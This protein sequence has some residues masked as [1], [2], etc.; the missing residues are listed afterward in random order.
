MT[1]KKLILKP[2][3]DREN[4]RYVNEGK[5]YSCDK[6]RF[7]QGTPEKI[8]GWEQ[9]SA[10]TYLGVARSLVQWASLSGEP[11]IGVGTN[12]KY[13][14]ASGGDYYDITPIRSSVVLNNPFDTTINDATVTVHDTAHGAITGDFVTFSG[15]TAVGGLDLNSEYQVTVVDVDT[16]T[17]EAASQASATVTGGGGATVTA[18][19]QLNVGL[20]VQGA[21]TGW[22]AGGWGLGPWGT[23][24]TSTVEI[25]IWNAANFG[26]NLVYGPRGGGIYYWDNSGGL[27]TRGVE[28]GA[29]VGASDTPDFQNVL[30]VSD[31]SRFVIAFGTNTIGSSTQDPMLI[32]WSDQED[33]ANWSPGATS[34]AGELRLS[35]GSAIISAIQTRQEIVVLTDSAVYSMQYAGAP[36]FWTV[37]LLGDNVSIASDRAVATASN[38]VYWMGIDKF[39]MYDG[40]VQTL[41]CDLRQY[42]FGDINASQ[43]D[44]IFS[45]TVEAFN[46]V[47]WF[48]CSADSSTV[49]RYVVYNYVEN[50]WYYGTLTRTAWVDS[51]FGQYPIAADP[52][53]SNLLYHEIGTDDVSTGTPVAIESYIESAEFDIDDGDRFGFVWRI[54]PDVTFR[55]SS[56]ASPSVIMTLKPLQN[57]GSGYND[58]LSVGGQS[59]RTVTR[60]AT[61]PVEAFT[62]QVNIR[63]RGRQMVMRVASTDLG[64][65]WQLG[66]PRIDVKADGRR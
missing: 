64:V 36:D 26:E 58:P 22:G 14:I 18:A 66:A 28:I 63:V 32:R 6:I 8:G 29:L 1:L 49:D 65:Q 31:A 25:R 41:N 3:V 19:Y 62:G 30:L 16:Y 48:Y 12:L 60:T 20:D 54:L 47:W 55:G 21:L 50:G 53:N 42:V 45:G 52:T 44:Q 34:Q 17:I 37:Q 39:Y 46:E 61:I 27:G 38:V 51:V 10:E 2:G 13:Y 5:W 59:S 35:R 11:F 15:A 9:V 40:R 43:N 7:R 33:V 57:S 24:T 23:G 56:A 4:T